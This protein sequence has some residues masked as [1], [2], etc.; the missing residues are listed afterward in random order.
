MTDRGILERIFDALSNFGW[1]WILGGIAGGVL[2]WV[3]EKERPRDGVATIAAGA[4]TSFY[5]GPATAILVG[6]AFSIDAEN[7]HLV[8]SLSFIIG[9]GG[10]SLGAVL[11]GLFRAIREQSFIRAV[12]SSLKDSILSFLRWKFGGG[13]GGPAV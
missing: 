7:P 9:V 12:A 13:G 10:I 2:K 4:L 5:L 1:V 8:A 11:V 6:Q 3:S